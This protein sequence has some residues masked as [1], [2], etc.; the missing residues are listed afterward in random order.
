MSKKSINA[1]IIDNVPFCGECGGGLR[2]Q[3]KDC[4]LVDVD[5]EKY[6]EFIK[7]CNN[8]KCGKLN[9]HLAD[10]TMDSTVRFTVEED[11]IVEI[12]SEIEEG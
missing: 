4:K 9:H 3:T 10:V 6:T 8:R 2:S 12:E 5:G 11:K 7:V 1:R